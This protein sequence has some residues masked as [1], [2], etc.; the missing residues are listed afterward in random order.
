M[1]VARAGTVRLDLHRDGCIG[2]AEARHGLRLAQLLLQEPWKSRPSKPYRP[3]LCAANV[4]AHA[5][6]SSPVHT[7]RTHWK[8]QGATARAGLHTCPVSCP[9]SRSCAMP[10]D[11]GFVSCHVSRSQWALP[12]PTM[13]WHE[14]WDAL[15]RGVDSSCTGRHWTKDVRVDHPATT[16]LCSSRPPRPQTLPVPEVAMPPPA[17]GTE[18][19][20]PKANLMPSALRNPPGGDSSTRYTLH[21]PCRP[22]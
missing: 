7:A 4:L 18:A 17:W 10:M 15:C 3:H 9:S 20:E 21:D 8:L 1:A 19:S 22:R 12:S 2:H 16:S 6:R 14:H 13:G 11:G 5:R